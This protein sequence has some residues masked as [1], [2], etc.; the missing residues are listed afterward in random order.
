MKVI[1]VNNGVTSLV[2]IPETEVEILQLRDLSKSKSIKI[3]SQ[4]KMIQIL[5]NP[6]PNALV[7][8]GTKPSPDVTEEI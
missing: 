1:I 8:S 5:N 4:E 7:I 2:L 3:E 6:A